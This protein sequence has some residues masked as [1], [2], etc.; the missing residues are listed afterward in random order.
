MMDIES[1]IGTL[2]VLVIEEECER[3]KR[4]GSSACSTFM[5]MLLS[6]YSIKR[7]C[8]KLIWINLLGLDAIIE[9]SD[10]VC[11]PDMIWRSEKYH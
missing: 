4:I 3:E 6:L 8:A 10:L 9:S 7:Y 2:C 1:S 11:S 5:R